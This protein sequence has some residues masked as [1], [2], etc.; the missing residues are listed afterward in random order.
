MKEFLETTHVFLQFDP[1][2][3]KDIT[4]VIELMLNPTS[5]YQSDSYMEIDQYIT[6]LGIPEL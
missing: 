5:R 1:S 6:D 2:L 3:K 4:E